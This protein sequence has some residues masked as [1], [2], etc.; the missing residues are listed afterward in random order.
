MGDTDD[1]GPDDGQEG[2]EAAWLTELRN[3]FRAWQAETGAALA[4][5][6]NRLAQLAPS[7]A[8]PPQLPPEWNDFLTWRAQ[9]QQEPPQQ[10]P[11]AT[12]PAAEPPAP[13][14]APPKSSPLAW[15]VTRQ[16]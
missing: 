14:P 10:E 2:I 5:L 3:D 8:Q 6:K 4:D 13:P 1:D 15:L 16:R 12:P 9:R 7:P 11:P